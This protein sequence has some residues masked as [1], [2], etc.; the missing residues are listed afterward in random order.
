M[1]DVYTFYNEEGAA[2]AE[3]S[4]HLEREWMVSWKESGC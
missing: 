3:G 2:M 1:E 4:L